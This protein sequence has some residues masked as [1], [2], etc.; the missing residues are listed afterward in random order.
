MLWTN[1]RLGHGFVRVIFINTLF[2]F[3][4][5]F[6]CPKLGDLELRASAFLIIDT[7]QGLLK[8]QETQELDA[9]DYTC[10]ATNDAGR[11]SGKITLDVGCK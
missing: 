4:L 11:A 9:G 2:I 7:H 10:V 1:L 8:I 3:Q 6:F 5:L